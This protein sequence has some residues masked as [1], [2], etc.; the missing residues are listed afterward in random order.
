[1]LAVFVLLAVALPCAQQQPKSNGGNHRSQQINNPTTAPVSTQTQNDSGTPQQGSGHETEKSGWK[2]YFLEPLRNSWPLVAIAIPAIC[3]AFRTIRVMR[4]GTERQLRAYLFPESV[5][6]WDG[7]TLSPPQPANAGIPWVGMYIKNS[8]QTPAYKVVSIMQL[9]VINPANEHTLIPLPLPN[10][11]SGDF[12][13]NGGIHKGA[14]LDRPLTAPEIAD[15]STGARAIYAYGR[16]EYI[17]AFR[18]DRFT[19]FRLKYVG[20]YPP[21]SSAIFVYSENGNDAN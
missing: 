15:I 20:P 21:L 13:P 14:W 3:A 7:T 9:A 12:G 6:V 2:L 16:I 8:G 17:D 19:N 5:G 1:M 18:R 4:E 11:F 10:T